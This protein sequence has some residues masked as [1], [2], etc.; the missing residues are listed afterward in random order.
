[1]S[2]LLGHWKQLKSENF[3]EYMKSM[4][5]SFVLRKVGN[6]IT[7]Y[8]E[9]RQNGDEWEIL[10]TS[11]FKNQTLKFKLGEEFDEHTM[12]G[13]H[14]KSTFTLEDDVLV[15]IQKATKVGV[16]DCQISRKAVDDD[17]LVLTFKNLTK[18]VTSVR[19]FKRY[20]P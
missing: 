10:V 20:T 13:R 4:D 16:C 2:T 3:D 11:T 9:I 7:S 1:M 5:V 8:E 18:D 15:Q 12:D 14:V 17:T 19:T 6:S